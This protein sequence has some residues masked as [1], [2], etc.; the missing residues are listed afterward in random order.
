[1]AYLVSETLAVFGRWMKKTL[2][3]PPFLFFSLVQPIVWFVLFTQA[4]SSVTNIRQPLPGGGFLT[5]ADFSGTNNFTTW[6]AAAV[7]IQTVI[8]SA[9]QSGMGIVQDIDSGY[10]DKMRV[11]PI[12]RAAILLGKGMSDA[13]RIVLQTLVILGLGFA[14]G[15]TFATGILGVLVL[16]LLAAGFGI[17]WSGISNTIALATKNSELTL[18]ISILTTFPLLFLSTAMM[19]LRLLPATVRGIATYNPITYIADGLHNLTIQGFDG[20]ILGTAFAITVVIGILT[21]T[22]STLMFRRATSS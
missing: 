14:L 13:V 1:M 4:F 6:F 17:A 3:R 16:L 12:S 20:G 21:V 10:L 11:A 2:R 15:M 22:S 8:A 9:M 5:F 19:P 18:M 7:V